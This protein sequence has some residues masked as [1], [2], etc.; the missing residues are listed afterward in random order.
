M[1]PDQVRGRRAQQAAPVLGGELAV[2]L[3]GRVGD[4]AAIKWFKPG[5]LAHQGAPVL[6]G[7]FAVRFLGGGP[8]MLCRACICGK[9][10]PYDGAPNVPGLYCYL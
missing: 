4:E 3:R 7:V 8:V 1:V 2:G 10:M 5:R 9:V 6:L